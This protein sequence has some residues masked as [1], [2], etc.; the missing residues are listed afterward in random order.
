MP[1]IFLAQNLSVL[2]CTS[3]TTRPRLGQ[4]GASITQLRL[5]SPNSA[6]HHSLFSPATQSSKLKTSSLVLTG[7]LTGAHRFLTGRTCKIPRVYRRVHGFTGTGVL[8]IY[9]P[10]SAPWTVDRGLWTLD[11]SAAVC[12]HLQP[13]AQ[14]INF[15]V[16]RPPAGGP[17]DFVQSF[18]SRPSF[19]FRPLAALSRR[20][21]GSDLGSPDT[22]VPP[23]SFKP[24]NC[25]SSPTVARR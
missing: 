2:I 12:N 25:L 10:P 20:R 17:S 3:T 6:H 11:L 18:G 24:K 15:S 19:G 5:T 14:K 4:T 21:S 22:P 8:H 13:S 23:S 1:S 16:C 9:H 7:D